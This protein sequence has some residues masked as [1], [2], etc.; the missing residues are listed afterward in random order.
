M[1]TFK[2]G[3]RV[4]KTRGSNWTG[5]VVGTYRT[6]LTPE[7]YAVESE[8]ECGSVQIYPVSALQFAPAVLHGDPREGSIK[9]VRDCDNPNSPPVCYEFRGGAWRNRDGWIDWAGGECPVLDCVRVDV[10]FRD[11]RVEENNSP[12]TWRWHHV[13]HPSRAAPEGDIVAYRVCDAPA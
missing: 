4:T 1:R 9:F 6:K 2:L 12:K 7:G 8:T 3:D 10:R 13:P 5:L 11:G